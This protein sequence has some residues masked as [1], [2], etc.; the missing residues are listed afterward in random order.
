MHPSQ[1]GSNG[2][3]IPG[4]RDTWTPDLASAPEEAWQTAVRR[5]RLSPF[6]NNVLPFALNLRGAAHI[7]K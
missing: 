5:D 7:R 4:D 3:L 1:R 2:I 6:A